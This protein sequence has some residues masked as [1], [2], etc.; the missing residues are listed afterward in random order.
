MPRFDVAPAW[1]ERIFYDEPRLQSELT[2]N[3][4]TPNGAVG[5]GGAGPPPSRPS[6]VTR[7]SKPEVVFR[8]ITLPAS[9]LGLLHKALRDE[10][11][12]LAAIHSLHDAGYAAGGPFWATFE[13]TLGWPIEKVEADEFWASLT[14]F[15]AE[16]G[17]GKLTHTSPHPG[18]GLLASP[19]WAEAETPSEDGPACSFTAGMLAHVLTTAAAGPVAVLEVGCRSRGD[20]ECVFA[21]GSGDAVHDLYGLLLDGSDLPDALTDL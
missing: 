11:G 7:M 15:M 9:T 12:D 10:A 13:S 18:V 4:S 16:R 2:R 21:F 1:L 19:D 8:E 6:I 20:A 3:H 17:W 5:S 14:G